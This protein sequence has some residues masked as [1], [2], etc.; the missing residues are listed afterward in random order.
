[1]TGAPT[2]Q[3]RNPAFLGSPVQS[4]NEDKRVLE[5]HTIVYD[6]FLRWL[7]IYRDCNKLP[8]GEKE[9]FVFMLT[10]HKAIFNNVDQKKIT[11][12]SE[13]NFSQFLLSVYKKIRAKNLAGEK[14][15][16]TVKIQEIVNKCLN[17]IRGTEVLDSLK[18]LIGLP[19]GIKIDPKNTF[20]SIK[21]G[22]LEKIPFIG[23]DKKEEDDEPALSGKWKMVKFICKS[24]FPIVL[25]LLTLSFVGIGPIMTHIAVI[26]LL[27]AEYK[28]AESLFLNDKKGT[29]YDTGSEEGPHCSCHDKDI[30]G[31]SAKLEA[32]RE[33][34]A[35][36]KREEEFEE[37]ISKGISEIMK[38][39]L[40]KEAENRENP[41]T[42]LEQ[43]SVQPKQ[44]QPAQWQQLVE[45]R[46]AAQRGNG[47]RHHIP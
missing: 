15:L 20:G 43:V 26:G 8:Q 31:Q 19:F 14:S 39:P 16:N 23:K 36:K 40:K 2:P 10:S 32:K 30:V 12:V 13:E 4:T 44:T 45:E 28:I 17:D 41:S 21:D 29:V 7:E 35:A 46:N 25:F 22:L 42:S 18:K 34:E 37:K 6:T 24:I 38:I 11:E 1:M 47:E 5:G 27:I 9:H 33:E 3:T